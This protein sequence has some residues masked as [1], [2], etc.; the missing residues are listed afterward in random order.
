MNETK[1]KDYGFF[2]IF[3]ELEH[4]VPTQFALTFKH[5][6]VDGK[7]NPVRFVPLYEEIFRRKL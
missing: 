2:K 7:Y 5:T 6:C 1:V 4:V 3:G